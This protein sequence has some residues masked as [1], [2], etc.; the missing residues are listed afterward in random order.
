MNE[1]SGVLGDVGLQDVL[2]LGGVITLADLLRILSQMKDCYTQDVALRA[3]IIEGLR[4]ATSNQ[5][6]VYVS[7]WKY[8]PLIDSSV[9]Q[10]LREVYE[11]E[12]AVSLR[13]N[14]RTTPHLTDRIHFPLNAQYDHE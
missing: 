7:T 12:S 1:V 8:S 11:T 2:I 14:T 6:A 4:E 13:T 10:Q 5:T 3:D 9:E